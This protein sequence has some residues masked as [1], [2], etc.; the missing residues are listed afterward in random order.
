MHPGIVDTNFASHGNAQMQSHMASAQLDPPE[1]SAATLAWLA[2]AVEPG[3]SSGR[4]WFDKAE[5]A[6]SA[7]AQNNE[8]AGRLWDESEKLLAKAGF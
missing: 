6:S 3:L 7:A 2:S 4:Y 5:T 1:R 8:D